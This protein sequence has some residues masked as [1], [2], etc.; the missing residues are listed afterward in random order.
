MEFI[1][2]LEVAEGELMRMKRDL[3]IEKQLLQKQLKE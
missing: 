1:D 3:L 2:Q